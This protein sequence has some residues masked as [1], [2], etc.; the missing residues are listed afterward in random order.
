M[1]IASINPATGE[2]IRTFEALDDAAIEACLAR[3][4][5]A[6]RVNRERSFA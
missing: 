1:A 3:A 4:S 2:T 6:F 5:S